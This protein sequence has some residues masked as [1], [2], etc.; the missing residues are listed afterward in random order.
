MV[1]GLFGKILK[2]IGSVASRGVRGAADEVVVP[3]SRSQSRS[4]LRNVAPERVE[5]ITTM[6]PTR[7]SYLR[8]AL[9]ETTEEASQIEAVRNLAG[10]SGGRYDLGRMMGKPISRDVLP[11]GTR[12][13]RGERR[14]IELEKAGRAI[15]GVRGGRLSPAAVR[16][17]VARRSLP[18][19]AGIIGGG[20]GIPGI[21]AYNA[22]TGESAAGRPEDLSE[23]DLAALLSMV[24]QGV[25]PQDIINENYGQAGQAAQFTGLDPQMV[26]YLEGRAA[27]YQ[28]DTAALWSSTAEA[29]NRLAGESGVGG[30]TGVGGQAALANQIAASAVPGG[31]AVSGLTPV[32][33]ELMEMEQGTRAEAGRSGRRSSVKDQRLAEDLAYLSGVA[34]IMG[35]EYGANIDRDIEDYIMAE[36]LR[37]SGQAREAQQI[38]EQQ[39]LSAIGKVALENIGAQQA[40]PSQIEEAIYSYAREWSSFTPQQKAIEVQRRGIVGV[41]E[42]ELQRAYIESRMRQTGIAR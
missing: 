36:T 12:I 17:F 18:V 13:G 34:Q 5:Q 15:P 29:I 6:L 27:Q 20:V 41:S 11:A 32:S 9:G 39:R 14:L 25:T 4:L 19:Q 33:P 28:A 8:R 31:T 37:Q 21:M 26:K 35:A 3:T 16:G 42:S 30:E 7:P 24:G 23:S 38:L 10:Y 40:T 22:L 1:S 2:G